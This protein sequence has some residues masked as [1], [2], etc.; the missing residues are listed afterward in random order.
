MEL[1][2]KMWRLMEFATSYLLKQILDLIRV[3]RKGKNMPKIQKN[4]NYGAFDS[5]RQLS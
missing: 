4:V 5:F 2:Q 1:S 3:K